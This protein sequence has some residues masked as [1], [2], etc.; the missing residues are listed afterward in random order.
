MKVFHI[1]LTLALGTL[2]V[3]NACSGA[4]D[5]AQN[6]AQQAQDTA[7]NATASLTSMTALKDTLGPITSGVS[8][9]LAAVKAGDFGKAQTEFTTLQTN[10]QGIRDT[11]SKT[12]PEA[13]KTISGKIQTIAADLK[14]T[15]P[16]PA[17]L[18]TEL[19][20]L[21]TSLGSFLNA[22]APAS[23][24][25]AADGSAMQSNLTVMQEEL[26]KTTTAVESQ[27]FAAAKESFTAAR[28][29]WFKFGG[30]V[31]QKS[32]D[33]YQK[34]EDGVKTANSDLSQTQPNRATLIIVLKSLS[35]DLASVK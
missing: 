23:T 5:Q 19:Q 2:L 33:T 22:K 18:T 35:S 3:L 7:N 11:V 29:A 1:N 14:L 13:A 15:P 32:A 20:G 30:S 8:Q 16:D 28:Q 4:S 25:P 31:K 34:L 26:A 12:A 9:T 17:K 27:D 24:S 6:M 10:W 21:S